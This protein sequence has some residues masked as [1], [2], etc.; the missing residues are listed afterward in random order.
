M[1]DGTPLNAGTGGDTIQTEQP[2]GV[3]VKYPVTKIYTG[4][5]DVNGG[6]VTPTNPLDVRVS[7]VDASGVAQPL[8]VSLRNGAQELLVSDRAQRDLLD[9]ANLT[10][11][12]IRDAV[13]GLPTATAAAVAPPAVQAVSGSVTVAGIVSAQIQGPNEQG[14]PQTIEI[15]NR[16]N[17]TSQAVFD[18]DNARQNDDIILLLTDIRDALWRGLGQ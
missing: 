12:D 1:G 15:V 5:L 3:G 7:A 17:L 14:Q 13:Q 10:L 18:G 9:A 8:A 11:A 4:A 16:S 6:P 2:G